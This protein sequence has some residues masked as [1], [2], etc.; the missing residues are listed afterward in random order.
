MRLVVLYNDDAQLSSGRREDAV[1][2]AAV[3]ASAQAVTEAC[4]ANGWP[5]L[6]LASAPDP[7][8]LI[9]QLRAA[10]P[11]LVFNLVESVR[12]EARL[13]AAVA[14]LLELL[15]LPY[16]GS[17]PPAL[18]LCLDKVSAK[19]VLR[20]AGVRVPRGAV[21]RDAREPLP[22]VPPPWIV[23]PSREDASH[24]IDAGSV[25]ASAEAARAKVAELLATYAQPILVE[26][27]V[28][29]RELNVALLGAGEA[30]TVLPPGE[31]DYSA[32][33]AGHPP[34]LTYAAKWD[35]ASPVF[36]QTPSVAAQLSPELRAGVEA[37]ARR[38]YAA[39]GL[40][41]YG[42]VDLR[43]DAAGDPV[44]LEVNPNPDL[45]PDAGF[46]RAAARAGWSYGDLI[47]RI[48]TAAAERR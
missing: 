18:S 2:V 35:E 42:R 1:A 9:A 34:I 23:K 36:G 26:E 29:G 19:A 12:G 6:A 21:L 31:I 46:A 3:A 43:L 4:L 14:G 28:P 5:A 39:L 7:A 20:E 15:A 13:E 17:P 40:R 24:G 48:V 32:L 45:S 30:A 11:D 33:P 47:G 22:E 27:L 16:T 10:A 38:A 41:D 44:V 37:T 25:V 8:A